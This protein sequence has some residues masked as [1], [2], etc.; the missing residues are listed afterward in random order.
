MAVGQTPAEITEKTNAPNREE[1]EEGQKERKKQQL[2]RRRVPLES[3]DYYLES[4]ELWNFADLDEDG[5]QKGITAI[6]IDPHNVVPCWV[7]GGSVHKF[8][9]LKLKMTALART[10]TE[11][12]EFSAEPMPED[13]QVAAERKQAQE[14]S[15]KLQTKLITLCNDLAALMIV[16]E[17]CFGKKRS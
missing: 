15:D 12:K 16:P 17:S 7:E 1:T 2:E 9:E 3:W 14:R 10:L 4:P 6:L 11:I 5:L 8:V 13:N